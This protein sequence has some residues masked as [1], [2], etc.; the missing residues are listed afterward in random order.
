MTDGPLV[1][2]WF[3]CRF[4]EAKTGRDK[5]PLSGAQRRP[6]DRFSEVCNVLA[7]RYFNWSFVSVRFYGACPLLRGSVMRGSTVYLICSTYRCC[8]MKY[9]NTKGSCVYM[10]EWIQ[11]VLC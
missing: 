7:E 11:E 10:F 6:L 9:M 1:W 2:V 8:M 5:C 3:R 4:L